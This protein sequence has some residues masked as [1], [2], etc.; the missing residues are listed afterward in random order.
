MS[1]Y[2]EIYR[3]NIYEINCSFYHIFTFSLI[4]LTHHP[5]FD[6]PFAI[7]TAY[8]PQNRVLSLFENRERHKKLLSILERNKYLFCN[9]EGCYSEH[10]EKGFIVFNM[11]LDEALSMARHF[12]QYAL[13]YNDT[14]RVKYIACEDS[15]VIVE[16][17]LDAM[18]SL[19]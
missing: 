11:T 9:A 8:N 6:Q 2:K 3:R 13:F 17:S 5:I 15:S 7:L 4:H 18:T 19:N 1:R 16:R 12:D 10:C 14:K